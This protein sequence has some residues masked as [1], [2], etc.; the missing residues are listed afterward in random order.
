MTR[1]AKNEMTFGRDVPF[2]E[3][4][5]DLNKVTGEEVVALAEEILQPDQFSIVSLGPVGEE[6]LPH[7]ALSL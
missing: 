3:I 4:L 5:E 1:I 2:E 6:D 7:P